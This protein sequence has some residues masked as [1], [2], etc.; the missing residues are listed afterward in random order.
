MTELFAHS[1]TAST[2][3]LD[4]SRLKKSAQSTDH[5]TKMAERPDWVELIGSMVTRIP[6]FS[7][8]TIAKPIRP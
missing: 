6:E 8:G 1:L 4:Y 3:R 2:L 5:E 7:Y